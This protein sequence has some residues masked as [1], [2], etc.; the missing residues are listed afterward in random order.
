MDSIRPLGGAAPFLALAT[1]GLRTP[2]RGLLAGAADGGF[3]AQHRRPAF[4]PLGVACLRP[5]PGSFAAFH[6]LLTLPGLPAG[7]GFLLRPIALPA[8][9]SCPG[10]PLGGFLA[11]TPLHGFHSL[12][13]QRYPAYPREAPALRLPDF[14]LAHLAL[15]L[16]NEGAA[17]RAGR[18]RARCLGRIGEVLLLGVKFSAGKI[19]TSLKPLAFRLTR[20]LSSASTVTFR[21]S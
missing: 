21:V 14:G 8:G 15:S 10:A 2:L 7:F 18:N 5:A 20:M 16:F 19:C 13:P 11:L 12:A 1:S 3:L 9:I 17:G 6:N 4:K